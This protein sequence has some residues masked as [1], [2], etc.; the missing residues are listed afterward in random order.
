MK[1]SLLS[2]SSN[3]YSFAGSN[4][5]PFQTNAIESL[6]VDETSNR[7][8]YGWDLVIVVKNPELNNV[9]DRTIKSIKEYYLSFDEIVDRLEM[10]ELELFLF[11]SLDR[12]LIFIKIK[13]PLSILQRHADE[14]E[15]LMRLDETYLK[16]KVDDAHSP[17]HH[18]PEI[19][20][21]HPYE[22]IYCKYVT[23]MFHMLFSL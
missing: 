8:V 12:K 17:I 22:N 11:Y 2:A 5:Q 21:L 10:A 23:G 1:K 4:Y 14:I 18:D 19:T 7:T 3:H 13:A 9:G 15:F 16:E 20:T 6:S